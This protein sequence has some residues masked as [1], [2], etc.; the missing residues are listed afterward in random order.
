[1]IGR[2]P[3]SEETKPTCTQQQRQ[4]FYVGVTLFSGRSHVQR[5]TGG[6][7]ADIA[8]SARSSAG[9][10]A[11]L[12]GAMSV[13]VAQVLIAAAVDRLLGRVSYLGAR[14]RP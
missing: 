4:S 11:F 6:K 1:M 3:P 2:P 14:F 13:S 7:K 12:A 9:Q 5:P 10:Q 8:C